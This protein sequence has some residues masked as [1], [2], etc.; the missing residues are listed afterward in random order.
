VFQY[1][2][3]AHSLSSGHWVNFNLLDVKTVNLSNPG[4]HDGNA[5]ANRQMLSALLPLSLS[6]GETVWIRW[7]DEGRR[8]QDDARWRELY[9]GG[10]GAGLAIDDLS[11][12]GVWASDVAVPEMGTMWAGGALAFLALL[13]WLLKDRRL[14]FIPRRQ[15]G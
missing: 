6:G 5:D 7:L 2:T 4:A 14:R 8:L 9:L 3:D 15:D 10:R 1:S 11:V 13:G 12:T